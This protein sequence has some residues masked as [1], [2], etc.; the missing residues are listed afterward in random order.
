MNIE[1]IRDYCL[2]KKAVTENFP[3]NET[4]LVFKVMNKMFLLTDLEK[5]SR[6][7]L[8][9]E[10]ERNMEL[11][12]EYP[13]VIGAFH[14]NKIHWNSVDYKGAISINIIEQLIDESYDIIV[15]GLTKKKKEELKNLK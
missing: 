10:T 3:F 2:T 7:T 5:G 9:N 8:K 15:S 14:M 12:E 13:D 6:I 11:R 4:V 1:E